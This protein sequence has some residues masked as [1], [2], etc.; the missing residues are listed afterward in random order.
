MGNIKHRI[1]YRY[2]PLL[3]LKSD[4]RQIALSVHHYTTL[5]TPA[6]YM[7]GDMVESNTCKYSCTEGYPELFAST[8]INFAKRSLIRASDFVTLISLKL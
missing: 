1:D 3:E 5:S 2:R 8:K 4:N 7:C 6:F